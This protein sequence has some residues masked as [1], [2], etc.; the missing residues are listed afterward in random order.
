MKTLDVTDAWLWLATLRNKPERDLP[1]LLV[2]HAEALR[3]V[4]WAV[5]T[6]RYS[7]WPEISALARQRGRT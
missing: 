7:D 6:G 4:R 5:I 3:F 1:L 2:E